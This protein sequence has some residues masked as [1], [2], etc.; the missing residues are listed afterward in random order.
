[1][2]APIM[3]CKQNELCFNS[4]APWA[5][6]SCHFV[7]ALK[8]SKQQLLPIYSEGAGR[9]GASQM[10]RLAEMRDNARTAPQGATAGR[11]GAQPPRALD[12]RP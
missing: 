10:G 2:R 3:K 9:Q 7:E 1:M 11:D 8:A 6:E 4:H 5:F 12:L